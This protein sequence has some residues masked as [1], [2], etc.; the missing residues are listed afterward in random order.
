MGKW[1]NVPVLITGGLGMIGSTI[2]I[3]LVQEGARIAVLDSLHPLYGGNLF[4]LEPH[5][6]HIGVCVA[7]IR[8]EAAVRHIVRGKEV[9]FNLAAQVSYTLSVTDPMLDL[10]VNCRG[11]L[12]LL[13][14]CRQQNLRPRVMFSS[15]RMVYG[16]T[17]SCPVS[18]T[19]RTDPLMPYAVHK[20]AAEKYHLMYSENYGIPCVIARIANP[21]GPRQQMKHSQYGIV[22]WFIRLAMEGGTIKIFGEGKQRRDYV[23]VDDVADALIALATADG[24]D[25]EIFNIGSGQGTAF[26]NMAQLVVETVR[27][28]SLERVPW[29]ANYANIETGDYVSDLTKI[30]GYTG[31]APK[32][33]LTEGV[34]ETYEYYAQH[35]SHYWS[36]RVDLLPR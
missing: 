29:P 3:K 35:R 31:W 8:D 4:N 23:Y 14:A 20:L 19:H 15:T 27:N 36:G 32:R 30:R 5:L 2:A 34:R 11:N 24:V 6:E 22:N 33:N 1:Q 12:V 26:E 18:E 25:G 28:G 13:E 9:I 21:Y 16:R 17:L 7:D 10:D